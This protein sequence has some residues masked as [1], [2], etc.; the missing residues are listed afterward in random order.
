MWKYEWVNKYARSIILEF[1][2]YNVNLNLISVGAIMFEFMNF[3]GE[4]SIPLNH[5]SVGQSRT[6]F[7]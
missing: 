2:M 5:E 7:L 4:L 3:G 1:T 6:A